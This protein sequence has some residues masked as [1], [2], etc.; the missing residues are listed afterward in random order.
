RIMA[1]SD[2]VLESASLYGFLHHIAQIEGCGIAN[3]EQDRNRQPDIDR[4]AHFHPG[5]T[6][7]ALPSHQPEVDQLLDFLSSMSPSTGW[8]FETGSKMPEGTSAGT[9]VVIEL[10]TTLRSP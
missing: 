4:R 1:A 5:I 2:R 6:I 7:H 10:G 3:D 8:H 9:I